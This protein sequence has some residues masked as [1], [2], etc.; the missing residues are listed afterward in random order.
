MKANER[1]DEKT[2]EKEKYIMAQVKEKKCV[3]VE[4]FTAKKQSV[5]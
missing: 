5:A 4:N 3:K 2:K 1:K